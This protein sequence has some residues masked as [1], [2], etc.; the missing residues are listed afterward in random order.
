VLATEVLTEAPEWAAE[1]AA[2]SNPVEPRGRVDL[3]LD[4]RV[5]AATAFIEKA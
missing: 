5:E 4:G 3:E 2:A 1:I